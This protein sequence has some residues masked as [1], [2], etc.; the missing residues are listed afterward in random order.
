MSDSRL[1]S[2]LRSALGQAGAG[3][4]GFS[5]DGLSFREIDSRAIACIR[6]L[7]SSAKN[8]S[9]PEG[10]PR[11]TGA[12]VGG[13]PTILCLRPGEW[14]AVSQGSEP[15][16]LL[17]DV[18]ARF[19]SDTV[20]CRDYSDALTLFRLEGSAAPWLL[21]KHCGLDIPVE[22]VVDPHCTRTRF[23]QASV[24][25]HYY[26]NT[27]APAYDVYIDRSLASYLWN[28]LADSTGHALELSE[29]F[30]TSRPGGRP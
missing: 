12:C 1:I 13:D 20:A 11:T 17:A 10:L 9:L 28:L 15:A 24:L 5:V 8:G 18:S 30:N 25:V 23:A 7:P 2:P 14:L 27:S 19:V 29:R 21:R 26:V 4:P 22:R 3:Q 16:E 6:S